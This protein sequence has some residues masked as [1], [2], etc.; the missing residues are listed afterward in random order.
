[1]KNSIDGQGL[2]ITEPI[3][4]YILP[5]QGEQI[6]M[7]A[8]EF[9]LK[10]K[11]PY[12]GKGVAALAE[13]LLALPNA[14]KDPFGNVHV[15]V[16]QSKT[17]FSSHMDT[18]HR[19]DGINPYKIILN[20]DDPETYQRYRAKAECLGADCAAGVAI[21]VSM[22]CSDVAGYYVLHDGEEV[23]CLGSRFLARDESFLKQFHRAIAFDRKGTT[24]IIT[25]QSG[26]ETAGGAFVYDLVIEFLKQGLS[27]AADD[28]GAY[29]DV[30]HYRHHIPQ[31]TNLSVGYHFAHS[32]KEWL[33]LV[34]LQKMAKACAKVQWETLSSAPL[35]V[36]CYVD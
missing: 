18:M 33:D 7:E 24:S 1:M 30:F 25:H 5:N 23:G 35:S 4:R 19:G 12:R 10:L 11:R 26:I 34:F 16:G 3:A 2:A 21:M 29:T 15:P 6:L 14:F 8:L 36:G 27:L 28:R 17:L 9:A 32:P 31:C 22:I 20:S 13:Y